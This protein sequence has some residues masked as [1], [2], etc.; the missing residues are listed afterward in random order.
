MNGKCKTNFLKKRVSMFHYAK[1]WLLLRNDNYFE[2]IL[3]YE[4]EKQ[5]YQH[6]S[7]SKLEIN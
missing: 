5:F 7:F 1:H 2:R 3:T 4:T 6:V